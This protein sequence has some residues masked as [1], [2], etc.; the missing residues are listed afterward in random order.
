[1]KHYKIQTNRVGLRTLLS[2]FKRG[3][4]SNESLIAPRPLP[5]QTFN[6][7]FAFCQVQS[8]SKNEAVL[9]RF[10]NRFEISPNEYSEQISTIEFSWKVSGNNKQSAS[11]K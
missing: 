5:R 11:E 1:M 2:S 7:Y 10:K 3:A 9:R 4:S 6:H 8:G